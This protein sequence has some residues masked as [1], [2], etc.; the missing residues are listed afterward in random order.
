MTVKE[1]GASHGAHSHTNIAMPLHTITTG[2][3]SKGITPSQLPYALGLKRIRQR[4]QEI[5]ACC[6]FHD[7]R[8]PSFS[9]N[10][11][12]GQWFCHAGCGSGNGTTLLA[13]LTNIDTRQAH[14]R[15]MEGCPWTPVRQCAPYR[16][17]TN[18]CGGSFREIEEQ[19]RCAQNLIQEQKSRPRAVEAL[20]VRFAVSRAT[21]YRRLEAVEGR[22]LLTLR[23]GRRLGV[24]T[25]HIL[26]QLRGF[27]ST[28]HPESLT[29]EYFPPEEPF[30]RA[31]LSR[32]RGRRR[33]ERPRYVVHGRFRTREHALFNPLVFSMCAS[34][35]IPW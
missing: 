31:R 35:A 8:T 5:S 1:T 15:L 19:L 27:V 20:M 4:G 24:R 7:D 3:D 16:R 25:L 2:A 29:G 26:K 10:V 11:E 33:R 6:P 14:A 34:S 17:K 21:A 22:M 18:R 13:R 12:T 9:I 23:Y 28:S 32:R 30:G